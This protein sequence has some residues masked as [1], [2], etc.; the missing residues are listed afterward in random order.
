MLGI[1]C[2]YVFLTK[3]LFMKKVIIVLCFFSQCFGVAQQKMAIIPLPEHYYFTNNQFT[4]DNTTAIVSE[5]PDDFETVY[6]ATAIKAQTGFNLL[7]QKASKATHKIKL[8]LDEDFAEEAYYLKITCTD[9]LIKAK[10]APGLFY[11]IQSF[12]QL[13]PSTF[14]TVKT[15]DLQGVVIHDQPKFAWRGMH[16]DVARHFFSKD[17]VKKYIDFLALYKMNVFHWHLTDDQGWRIQIKK[18]PK[19]TQ[20]GAWRNGSMIGH[21]RE[22]KFDTLRYGGYYTQEEIK[23]VVAYAQERHITIV[24]EIEMPGHAVAAIASYPFLSCT[25]NAIE[26]EKKW[27][28]FDDVFCPKNET[29]QFLEDVLTEVMPLFPSE[30]IH[31]GGD[32]CPKNNW[33]KCA[34]CQSLIQ[35]EGLKDEH[36]LQSYFIKRIE[37]FINAHGKKIIGWDEILE[38]GLAPNAAVMSWRGTEGGIAAAKLQHKVVM[39][40]GSHCYFDHYQGD[41]Q[42]EPLAI[43]GYTT[44]EK[45]Y[46][47]N[48]V[49]KELSDEQKKY[50]LGAQANVWTEYITN[51]A[52]VEYMVFPRI[53]ALSEV[54]WGTA[55]TQ[56]FSEFRERLFTHF[57]LLDAKNIH[58]SKSI[59]NL[60]FES[61]PSESKP[62]YLEISL[63]SALQDK[64]TFY[65]LDGSQPTI[66]SNAYD[67]PIFI[68]RPATLKTAYF[69]GGISKGKTLEQE[70]IFSKSTAQKI[71]LKNLPDSRYFGNGAVGLIDGIKGNPARFGKNWLGFLGKDMEANLD[72]G[73]VTEFSQLK[74][75][76]VNAEESWIYLPSEVA[77]YVSKDGKKYKLVKK[78]NASEIQA[79]NGDIQL[80]LEKK[81]KAQYLKVILKNYGIIPDGKEGGGNPAW[82]F[83][84]EIQ[85]D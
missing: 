57:N 77:L 11:G 61:K 29:F 66:A 70:I 42:N 37:K 20:I 26:V 51:E 63:L 5:E 12:L 38:G 62:G 58:Y 65:T 59:F 39:S 33:K 2:F 17:F 50:I 49:P 72:L 10:S 22:Q 47:F 36:E 8:V 55:D 75:T 69:D 3:E 46:S 9:I 15:V 45:V 1:F 41:P 81:K 13:L 64:G 24:P 60:S 78:I 35:K 67:K 44:L 27:G 83:V 56:K 21:Y 30:Y 25:A 34:H 52:H 79:I 40:P 74:L 85:I 7:P 84:D 14:S 53:C 48:P 6:L 28:V 80:S 54:L 43:G 76:A 16:L 4:L 32:E 71:T 23:E 68:N 73:I 31:I 82:L 19:L 18:Y